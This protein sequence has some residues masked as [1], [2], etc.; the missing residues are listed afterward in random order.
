[1]AGADSV[2]GERGSRALVCQFYILAALVLFVDQLS[3]SAV[4]R[5]YPHEFSRSIIP[6]LLSFTHVHNTGAAFGMFPASAW[7]F[8]VVSLIVCFVLVVWGRCLL[9]HGVWLRIALSLE[10]GGA[11]GNLVDRLSQGHVTDFIDL[12][13]SI[14]LLKD[15]P[16]FNVADIALTTG[17]I[18]IGVH[19]LQDMKKHR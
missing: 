6:G 1:M 12:D 14:R 3:K 16:V 10:L 8:V 2:Q 19:L 18:C 13:T 17:A 4:R 9:H 7:L 15:Y 5:D 11:L